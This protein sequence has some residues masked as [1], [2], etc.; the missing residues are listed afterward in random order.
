MCVLF[1]VFLFYVNGDCV[2][3][4]EEV[5]VLFDEMF[6]FGGVCVGGG[7]DDVVFMG[8]LMY[9]DECL[10]VVFMVNVGLKLLMLREVMA[11]A[12]VWFGVEAFA[13]V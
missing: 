10:G 6:G 3:V 7:G 5:N 4:V 12:R 1:F 13:L 8:C 2:S 11:S 9:V